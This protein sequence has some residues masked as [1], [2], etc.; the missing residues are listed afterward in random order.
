MISFFRKLRQKIIY[1]GKN[2]KYLKYAMGE[3]IH[4]VIGVLIALQI[5]NWN[6]GRK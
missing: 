2:M 4:G 1:E 6:E 5:N 3:I